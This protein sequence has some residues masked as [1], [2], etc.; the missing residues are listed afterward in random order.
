ME[1]A[2]TKLQNLS[3]KANAFKEHGD[4]VPNPLQ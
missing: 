4:Y 3:V 2:T 1:D